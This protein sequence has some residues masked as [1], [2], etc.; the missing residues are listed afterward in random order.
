MKVEDCTKTELIYIINS[1]I[2][3]HESGIVKRALIDIEYRRK[4]EKLIKSQEIEREASAAFVKY[5]D[6]IK[7][8]TD[9]QGDFDVSEYRLASA[10]FEKYKNLTRQADKL[11]E[12][13]CRQ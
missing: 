11:Y 7:K 2:R 4:R 5:C 8:L 6:Q 9:S 13:A 3:A 10:Y 12:E 1:F